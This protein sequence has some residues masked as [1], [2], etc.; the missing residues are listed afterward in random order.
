MPSFRQRRQQFVREFR[1]LPI[2]VDDGQQPGVDEAAN[3]ILDSLFGRAEFVV[4]QVI[5]GVPGLG[6]SAGQ[7]GRQFVMRAHFC[8]PS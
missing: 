7:G 5:I 2:V 8:T 6:Q 1:S 4:K 3:L